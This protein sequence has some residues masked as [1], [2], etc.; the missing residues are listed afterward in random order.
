MGAGRVC[1]RAP[2]ELVD[3]AVPDETPSPSPTAIEVGAPPDTG[4]P[5]VTA[6]GASGAPDAT[7]PVSARMHAVFWLAIGC[8]VVGVAQVPMAILARRGPPPHDATALAPVASGAPSAVAAASAPIA[9]ESA[10]PPLLPAE[11]ESQSAPFRIAQL[12]S[13]NVEVVHAKV[14]KR[15]CMQALTAV[16]VTTTD[17]ARVAV[18]VAPIRTLDACNAEDRIFVATSKLDHRLE[19]LELE[20]SP[21]EILRVVA[22]ARL[23]GAPAGGSPDDL[24]AEVV[25]LPVTHRR[26]ATAFVVGDGVASSIAAAGLDPSLV[27]HLDEAIGSRTD[28]PAP[29]RGSVFRV[30]A[31]ATWVGGQF[32]RYDELVAFEYRPRPGA[33]PLRLYH[34]REAAKGKNHG[35]FDGKGHQPVR[36]KWRMPLAFPKITSRFNPKRVHPILKRITPHNGCDFGAPTGTPVYA[37]GAGVVT[38]R[39]EAGP[40]GNLITIRHEGGIDSGYAHLSR[41]APGIVPGTRVEARTLVGYVGTTGR[42]TGPHLHLSVKRNGVFIDPLSLKMDAFRVVPRSERTGFAARKAEADK[43]LDA[44]DLPQVNPPA[45]APSAEPVADD[46]LE[47]DHPH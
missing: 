38:F 23:P 2:A 43:A 5:A 40:S 24:I 14:G 30:I 1:T 15:T 12:E 20:T 16:G 25:S 3:G 18:V 7:T 21:G 33:A 31:D 9:P 39:G 44:I 41:F 36:A 6:P 26:H 47:D 37:I 19:G 29:T 4:Q 27:E 42:S 32:D 10:A 35:W 22:R 34:V 13:A 11:P 17:A 8:A 28:V 45:A 46:M